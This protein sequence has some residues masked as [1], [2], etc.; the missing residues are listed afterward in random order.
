M[1]T[2]ANRHSYALTLT[3]RNA[4]ETK[5]WNAAFQLAK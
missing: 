3:Q 2:Y 4:L 5:L 1:N